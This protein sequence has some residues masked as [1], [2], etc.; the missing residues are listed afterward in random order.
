[1]ARQME[2]QRML[3][4]AQVSMH[5]YQRYQV[6]SPTSFTFSLNRPFAYF[7]HQLEGVKHWHRLSRELVEPPSLEVFQTLLDMV[8][9]N[10]L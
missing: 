1:M 6:F 5:Y 8:L 2:E 7:M 4:L 3:S 9:G 10:L